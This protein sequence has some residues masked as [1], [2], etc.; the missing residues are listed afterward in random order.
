MI[1]SNPEDAK[2]LAT[3]AVSILE[4]TPDILRGQLGAIFLLAAARNPHVA[5]G[6]A[7]IR[8]LCGAG[9]ANVAG[10]DDDGSQP[11]HIAVQ[12]DYQ[13]VGPL[14]AGREADLPPVVAGG[15]APPHVQALLDF[16]APVN[17]FNNFGLT[18]LH[19]AVSF[20]RRRGTMGGLLK[21]LLKRGADP[22]APA[23]APTEGQAYWTGWHP[24][25]FAASR[26]RNQGA[27]A[28][29][30]HILV[31]AGESPSVAAGE[32]GIQ[33]L[34]TVMGALSPGLR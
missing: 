18:P 15:V 14:L 24:I 19:L 13:V 26:N 31:A 8:V 10:R 30:V 21:A 17:R 33:P 11:L 28:E 20:Q 2:R 3:K 34:H 4:D 9:V 6:A 25:H 5:A 16:R 7:A 27:A 1:V 22:C 23:H 29:A 32:E 12:H